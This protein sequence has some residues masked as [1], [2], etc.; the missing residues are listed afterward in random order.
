MPHAFMSTKPPWLASY[1]VN[2]REREEIVMKRT[3]MAL[4]SILMVGL[5]AAVSASAEPV[6]KRLQRQKARI[7]RGVN[8]GALTG[9]EWQRLIRQHR[10]IKRQH[11]RA[12]RDGNLSYREGRYLHARLD[13][14]S[15]KIYRF[16]HN[17][18]WARR[19]HHPHRGPGSW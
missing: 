1:E 10:Q 2:A 11:Q 8:S 15:R 17:H 13:R 16:K 14:A 6:S 5:L 3:L 7:Y 19:H 9:D 18:Q 4:A 12:W